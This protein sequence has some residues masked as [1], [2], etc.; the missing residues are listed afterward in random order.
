MLYAEFNLGWW[1][2]M[3]PSAPLNH[4]T[5]CI[6][7]LEPCYHLHP[8][9]MIPSACSFY[10][11]LSRNSNLVGGRAR[12][13]PHPWIMT[14]STF[15]P[16]HASRV[17][18][19]WWVACHATTFTPKSWPHQ[20]FPLKELNLGRR[21][22]VLPSSLLNHEPIDIISI[23]RLQGNWTVLV[24]CDDTIFTLELQ[25]HQRFLHIVPLGVVE[26]W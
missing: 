12:Y 7:T 9:T 2:T 1:H 11:M 15:S 3:L 25:P 5:I 10:H 26:P 17:I 4:A 16:Y 21:H 24:A 14:P 19:P 8:W 22:T 6:S 20:H 13:H 18:E 23:S